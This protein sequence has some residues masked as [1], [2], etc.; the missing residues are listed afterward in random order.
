MQFTGSELSVKRN[1]YTQ[2]GN[3]SFGM[4]CTVDNT[5][6]VYHFGVS[7][8]QTNQVVD[9]RLEGGKMYYQD[10]FVHT[11]RSFED[12]YVQAE[13]SSGQANVS[14]NEAPLLYGNAKTTG[15]YDYFYFNRA[16][17]S[18]GAT[19]D[20]NISGNSF[21]LYQIT[22]QGY[23]SVSG[24]Q[25]VTGYYLNQSAYPIR[26]F[27]SS[28]LA[29]QPYTFGKL[30]GNIT[31]AN[32]GSFAYTGDFSTIDITQPIITTFNTN[33]GDQE[34]L[35][36]IIDARSFDAFVQLTGPTS[37]TFN[38]SSVMNRDVSYLNFSGGVTSNGFNTDL[39]FVLGYV[40]GS[41]Y[42]TDLTGYSIPAIGNFRESGYVTGLVETPTGN[43]TITGTGWATGA[44]TGFFSGMGTGIASG[45]NYT[46]LATGYM[47]GR[48]TGFIHQNSGTVILTYPLV[49]SGLTAIPIT[50]TGLLYATGYIDVSLLADGDQFRIIRPNGT[51]Y[52]LDPLAMLTANYFP[53]DPPNCSEG[54]GGTTYD[55]DFPTPT[56]LIEC[57][58]GFSALGVNGVYDGG[59]LIY[60]TATTLGT[61]GNGIAITGLSL[62]DQLPGTGYM[63]GGHN[64]VEPMMPVV[65]IG[66]PYTGAFPIT[67]TGSGSYTVNQTGQYY[68]PYV[69]TFTDSWQLSTGAGAGSLISFT[70]VSPTLYSGNG[71]FP[72]N[73]FV[74]MQVTYVPSGSTPDGA[75]LIV[76]GAN[77]INGIHQQL[78]QP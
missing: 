14:K 68:L 47:T 12:F 42:F 1:F 44:A 60:F 19:F 45:I 65:L 21:P 78:T 9:F 53:I 77:V 59:D 49:G 64:G 34:I 56:D 36:S 30:A 62:S 31:S 75:Y 48:A 11:Y 72:P 17:A 15:L 69:K 66:Q 23:L 74:N 28:I 70:A 50:P 54:P 58:S 71:T 27:D 26:I 61:F 13:F 43:W 29:V 38:S 22:S 2:T 55:T 7:G 37:F 73:S 67:L 52:E 57:M 46:G 5:T 16:N 41:G 51:D 6:G 18:L 4:N 76:T 32:S 39:T 8:S 3:F 63:T 40:S 10:Q 20:L 35:F 33:F 25:S 24:Q